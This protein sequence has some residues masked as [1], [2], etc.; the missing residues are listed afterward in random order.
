MKNLIKGILKAS[1]IVVILLSASLVNA[2][3]TNL[4]NTTHS[5]MTPANK[6]WTTLYYLDADY[7]GGYTDPLEQIFIDEI[8]STSQ[9]NVVVIQDTLND[10]EGLI[11]GRRP[12]IR[13]LRKFI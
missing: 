7:S 8:A 13:R 1:M 4:E 2:Q 5:L 9:V 6:A 11:H 3:S 10:R 12:L